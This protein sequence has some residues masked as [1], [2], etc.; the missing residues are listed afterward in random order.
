M[1][2]YFLVPEAS[3]NGKLA[4]NYLKY[5]QS[6]KILC[7]HKVP[8][9]HS[10]RK[11]LYAI[12]DNLNRAG[13]FYLVMFEFSQGLNW[14]LRYYELA[15]RGCHSLCNWI[16]YLYRSL[17]YYLPRYLVYVISFLFYSPYQSWVFPMQPK[18]LWTILSISSSNEHYFYDGHLSYLRYSL[19]WCTLDTFFIN[20][21]RNTKQLR[22]HV[23]FWAPKP[24][25]NEYFTFVE[26]SIHANIFYDWL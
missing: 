12:I 15:T 3:S 22:K 16:F 7:Q 24:S 25:I 9:A 19:A 2:I 8:T 23:E 14:R 4:N 10:Y 17:H 26:T 18:K 13:I 1:Q 5:I 11:E 21:T 20:S 6:R